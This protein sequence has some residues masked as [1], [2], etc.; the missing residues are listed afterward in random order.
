MKRVSDAGRNDD[1][2]DTL[3]SDDTDSA[4]LLLH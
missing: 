1:G 4:W 3:D 2:L